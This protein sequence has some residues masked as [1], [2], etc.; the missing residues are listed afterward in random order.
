MKGY[1]MK[2]NI[3]G[4]VL[5][6]G[7]SMLM[8]TG[9]NFNLFGKEIN[10]NLPWEKEESIESK[11]D[12]SSTT[13]NDVAT[14]DGMTSST[15]TDDFSGL[16]GGSGDLAT[17]SSITGDSEKPVDHEPLTSIADIYTNGNT[18]LN[19]IDVVKNN[20]SD[21]VV[22]K[23]DIAR[24]GILDTDGVTLLEEYMPIEQEEKILRIIK[25]DESYK[26][27]KITFK[28]DK[29]EAENITYEEKHPR[30]YGWGTSQHIWRRFVNSFNKDEGYTG[31]WD[32][33]AFTNGNAKLTDIKNKEGYNKS[34]VSNTKK[35]KE[36]N[37]VK[38]IS[39]NTAYFLR[40]KIGFQVTGNPQQAVV[41][42][43]N[44]HQYI[45]RVTTPE[46]I[47][48]Q[49]ETYLYDASNYKDKKYNVTSE[50]PVGVKIGVLTKHNVTFTK[51]GKKKK[52]T[53]PYFYDIKD[54][55]NY[56]MIFPQDVLKS[57]EKEMNII[58]SNIV[59]GLG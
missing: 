46:D 10:F 38:L 23:T 53:K 22:D 42:L 1:A 12:T 40:G 50:A 59:K 52:E 24:A 51:A 26:D 31:E 56:L 44:G 17:E 54:S 37:D 6:C 47:A 16:T 7:L 55:D 33:L 19:I 34:N 13:G 4:L 21:Q 30:L 15:G 11:P 41:T 20:M 49:L 39:G 25:S 35:E 48:F 57:N 9:C 2:K 27:Y 8:T 3:K 45:V 18:K 14:D 32:G 28:I 5:V 36:F 29:E 58:V 43:K